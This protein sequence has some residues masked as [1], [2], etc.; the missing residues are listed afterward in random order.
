MDRTA[1]AP[2]AVGLFSAHAGELDAELEDWGPRDGADCGQPRMSGRILHTTADGS[3]EVGVWACT[4]GGWAI[5]HRPDTETVRILSG[6]ARLTDAD[7]LAVDL[8]PGDVLVLPKGWSGRW[9]ILEP[10]RKL[11]V[12]AL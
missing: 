7:G 9:D 12:L 11:Y 10:V 3:V 5:S 6:R 2:P 8:G 4:P 1:G